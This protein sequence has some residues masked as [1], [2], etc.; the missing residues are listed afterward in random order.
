MDLESENWG[1]EVWE[2]NNEATVWLERL[3]EEAI[4][5]SNEEKGSFFVLGWILKKKKI[6]DWWWVNGYRITGDMGEEWWMMTDHR[7]GQLVS[8]KILADSMRE[9]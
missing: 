7:R 8:P 4:N 9:V 1:F 6:R 5:G 2:G 3:R